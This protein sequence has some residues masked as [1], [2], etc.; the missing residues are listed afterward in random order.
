MGGGEVGL[1]GETMGLVMWR[2][3]AGGG[4]APP[5]REG[6]R[7]RVARCRTGAAALIKL[8]ERGL[9]VCSRPRFLFGVAR[10]EDLWELQSFRFSCRSPVGIRL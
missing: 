8:G 5:L 3:S 9:L 10:R 2:M 4:V 1:P 7:A 6:A